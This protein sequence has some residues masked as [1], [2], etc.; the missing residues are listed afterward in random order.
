[1]NKEMKHLPRDIPLSLQLE[2][3]FGKKKMAEIWD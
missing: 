3:G 1:V 2:L